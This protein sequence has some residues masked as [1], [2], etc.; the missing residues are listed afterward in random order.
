MTIIVANIRATRT[1][2]YVG[3]PMPRQ[4]L[5]GSPLGNPFPVPQFSRDE[6]LERY[7]DWLDDQLQRD[8]PARRAFDQLVA[9]ARMGD[10]TLLCW[11]A[12]RACHAD[13]LKARIEQAL[14][15]A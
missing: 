3:R 8:T 1:G 2:V 9:Q 6:A 15:D 11:C 14:E 4:R 10:L 5:P 13:I 12:P 7:T